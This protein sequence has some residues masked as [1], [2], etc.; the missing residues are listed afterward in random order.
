MAIGAQKTTS[1]LFYV[2][3]FVQNKFPLH[4]NIKLSLWMY[5]KTTSAFLENASAPATAAYGALGSYMGYEE[6]KE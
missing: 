5:E 2:P 3:S 6:P 1:T 4:I